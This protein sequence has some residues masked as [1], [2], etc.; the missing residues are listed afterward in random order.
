MSR[1]IRALHG[2]AAAGQGAA[3]TVSYLNHTPLRTALFISTALLLVAAV[4]RESTCAEK[5]H[6]TP[7]EQAHHDPA[8]T[9][10][11]AWLH[12]VTELDNA[13]CE[14]WWTSLATNHDPTCHNNQ[15]RSTQ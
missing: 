11:Q 15:P 4:H 3:A 12:A 2:L 14:R 10:I 7:T 8:A 9:Q 5:H 6:T 1:T 13:C